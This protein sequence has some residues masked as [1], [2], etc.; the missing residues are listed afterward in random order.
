M[1][2]DHQ[3]L[4]FLG[5]F[6]SQLIVLAEISAHKKKPENPLT[7]IKRN[8]YKFALSIMGALAGYAF[9]VKP[10]MEPIMVFGLGL[11]ADMILDKIMLIAGKATYEKP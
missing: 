6:T 8:P 11:G 4:L 10:E 7:H 5:W 1:N 2:I 9:F 3:L